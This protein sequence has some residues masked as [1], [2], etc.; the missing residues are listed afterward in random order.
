MENISQILKVLNIHVDYSIDPAEPLEYC[1]AFDLSQNEK[2]EQ[3]LNRISYLSIH[4]II[5]QD[6][7]V[8]LSTILSNIHLFIQQCKKE[9]YVGRIVLNVDELLSD[10]VICF[11][12]ISYRFL[13]KFS[14]FHEFVFFYMVVTVFFSF[15]YILT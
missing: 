13:S 7:N 10:D 11:L 2:N 15:L 14:F 4:S 5:N 3:L 6:Q 9:E 12:L 8:I 1:H